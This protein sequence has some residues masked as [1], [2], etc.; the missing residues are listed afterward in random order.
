[1]Q[2]LVS[3]IIVFFLSV[4]DALLF[5]IRLKNISVSHKKFKRD[6]FY[7]EEFPGDSKMSMTMGRDEI[8]LTLIINRYVIYVERQ[9]SFDKHSF[10]VSTAFNSISSI[11]ICGGYTTAIDDITWW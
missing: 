4:N 3:F 7:T 5:L 2:L 11:K 6:I 1:M 9:W 8:G 10:S